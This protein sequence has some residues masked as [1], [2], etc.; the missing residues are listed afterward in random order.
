M[1]KIKLSHI[2]ATLIIGSMISV[3]QLQATDLSS[4]L[5]KN[6]TYAGTWK[7]QLQV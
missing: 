3:Q 4:I 5:L 7:I 1:R 6:S 2:S